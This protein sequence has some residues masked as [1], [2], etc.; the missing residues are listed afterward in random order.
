MNHYSPGSEVKAVLPCSDS[1]IS[2]GQYPLFSS[3]VEKI[4]A[5]SREA[6]HFSMRGTG[7]E[8]NLL[9]RYVYN[10]QHKCTMFRPFS[11]QIQLV[12]SIL[13]V[14]VL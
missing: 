10:D 6:I 2:T 8:S 1:W 13:F 14:Q 7:F 12:R 3:E 11:K 5:L 9:R 4:L